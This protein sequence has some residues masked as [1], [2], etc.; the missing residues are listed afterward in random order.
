MA[1]RNCNTVGHY[2]RN[3]PDATFGGASARS[4]YNCKMLGHIARNCPQVSRPHP[5]RRG[6]RPALVCYSCRQPGHLARDCPS[7]AG[8]PS[9]QAAVPHA[10]APENKTHIFRCA[11]HEVV[12]L[13]RKGLRTHHRPPRQPVSNPYS[14]PATSPAAPTSTALKLAT[15]DGGAAPTTGPPDVTQSPEPATRKSKEEEQAFCLAATLV[16]MRRATS[17][18]RVT[19]G[20]MTQLITQALKSMGICLSEATIRAQIIAAEEGEGM[21]VAALKVLLDAEWHDPSLWPDPDMAESSPVAPGSN[22]HTSTWTS[23]KLEALVTAL[24]ARSNENRANLPLKMGM[25]ERFGAFREVALIY[26]GFD[27]DEAKRR[28]IVLNSSHHSFPFEVN[29]ETGALTFEGTRLDS[30]YAVEQIIAARASRETTIP[31]NFF[32]AESAVPARHFPFSC[33]IAPP[34]G[35]C[36]DRNPVTN[37]AT[38][39]HRRSAIL[40]GGERGSGKTTWSVYSLPSLVGGRHG[41]LYYS[42]TSGHVRLEQIEEHDRGIITPYASG[43]FYSF[44]YRKHEF[45]TEDHPKLAQAVTRLRAAS[46]RRFDEERKRDAAALRMFFTIVSDALVHG[47]QKCTEVQNALRSMATNLPADIRASRFSARLQHE[48]VSLA[49]VIDEA[50]RYP[51]FVRSIVGLCREIYVCFEVNFN[52]RLVIAFCGTGT[53]LFHREIIPFRIAGSD[54]P[55]VERLKVVA[56]TDNGLQF[57]NGIVN[58]QRCTHK[59]LG[60]L[61]RVEELPIIPLTDN[62]GVWTNARL[63]AEFLDCLL[64]L[65]K[66]DA[67]LEMQCQCSLSHAYTRFLALNGLNGYGPN[68]K[69]TLINVAYWALVHRVGTL[70]IPAS[71]EDGLFLVYEPERIGCPQDAR[72]QGETG[73]LLRPGVELNR[74]ERYVLSTLRDACVLVGLLSM[75]RTEYTATEA[76]RAAIACGFEVPE[77][78]KG[79]GAAFEVLMSLVAKRTAEVGGFKT[80]MQRLKLPFPPQNCTSRVVINNMTDFD[81]IARDLDKEPAADSNGTTYVGAAVVVINGPSAESAD[82]IKICRVYSPPAVALRP[83]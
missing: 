13:F 31:P 41:V 73:L 56:G 38:T 10:A 51:G 25:Q 7:P 23:D 58:A 26:V 27:N 48:P 75:K 47:G 43:L 57:A 36:A 78:D 24:I 42:F 54:P 74:A 39:P 14:P 28:N 72:P 62:T 3:C 30:H 45:M 46:D 53:E 22:E 32:Q 63:T 83:P 59:K 65:A 9:S 50:G 17:T 35:P 64:V 5:P 68:M 34:N 67:P 1:C 40:V 21:D 33:R 11:Q 71:L 81:A 52:I 37:C 49:L 20:D 70:E 8:V 6:N 80:T 12:R 19:L 82:V 79:D 66:F 15:E 29:N 44:A 2:A 77:V 4:C 18:D 60:N 69:R 55:L 76:L 61:P 16:V